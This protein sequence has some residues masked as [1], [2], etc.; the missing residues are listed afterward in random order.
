MEE[1]E[2]AQVATDRLREAITA[3]EAVARGMREGS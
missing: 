1:G 2:A 3:L